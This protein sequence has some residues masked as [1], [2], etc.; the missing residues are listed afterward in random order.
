MTSGLTPYFGRTEFSPKYANVYSKV[1][2]YDIN[3][4]RRELDSEEG[5]YYFR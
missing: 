3:T 4:F 2:R 5:I 1:S